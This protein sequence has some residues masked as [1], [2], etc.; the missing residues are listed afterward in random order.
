MQITCF[1]VDGAQIHE[2]KTYP[3]IPTF[4]NDLL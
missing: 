3:P 1:V 2:I 4:R